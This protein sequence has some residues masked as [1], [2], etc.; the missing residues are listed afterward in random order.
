MVARSIVA[1]RRI[2]NMAMLRQSIT[3]LWL[4]LCCIELLLGAPITTEVD[5]LFMLEFL[6]GF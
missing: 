3:M 2:E 5:V 1:T 4:I 6:S